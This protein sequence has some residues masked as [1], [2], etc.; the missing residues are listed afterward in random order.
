MR[1]F[2][3]VIRKSLS[4]VKQLKQFEIYD[5]R[6]VD[7]ALKAASALCDNRDAREGASVANAGQ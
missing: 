5:V 6:N 7:V 2:A 1:A 3:R 4:L